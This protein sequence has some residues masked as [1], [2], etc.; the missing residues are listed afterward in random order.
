[1]PNGALGV[2][3]VNKGGHGRDVSICASGA[4]VFSP[5]CT[6]GGAVALASPVLLLLISV[7]LSPE[8]MLFYEEPP[9]TLYLSHAFAPSTIAAS[10]IDTNAA[11]AFAEEGVA[12][13]PAAVPPE[14]IADVRELASAVFHER[15]SKGCLPTVKV[16]ALYSVW[17][18]SPEMRSFWAALGPMIARAVGEDEIR[19]QEDLII[20]TAQDR[21]AY[22]CWHTDWYS[23][24]SVAT[25]SVGYS[26]W[27][28]LNDVN[29]SLTGGSVHMCNRSSVPGNCSGVENGCENGYPNGWCEKTLNSVCAPRSYRAGD[30][31]FFSADTLHRTQE[32]LDP[33]FRRYA[34]I[35]RFVGGGATYRARQTSALN[36]WTYRTEHDSCNH[37][38]Q[39]G[40]LLTGACVPRIHPMHLLPAESGELESNQRRYLRRIWTV[41]RG[42]AELAWYGE[43][44]P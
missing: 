17:N 16:N 37:Q 36:A 14:I 34:I 24:G 20:V 8:A 2:D 38:F 13:V 23:F 43:N 11:A 10:I 28:P 4:A 1:M 19:L 40:A 6:V 3:I 27:I 5:G 31:L 21:L 41:F 35:G 32:L 25:P 9:Q 15:R 44:L 33:D 39:D 30:A 26:V 22:S 18:R 29:A 12:V 42:A 7:V